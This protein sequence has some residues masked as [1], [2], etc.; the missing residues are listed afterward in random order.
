MLAIASGG[1]VR[2]GLEDNIHYDIGRKT[3]ATNVAL[4]KRIHELAALAERPV[5]LPAE[6]GA[7]GFYN[8]KRRIYEKVLHSWAE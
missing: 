6:F 7:L 4:V 1:G 8:T 3:L 5:M 2:V